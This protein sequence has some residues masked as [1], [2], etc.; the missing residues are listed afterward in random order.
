MLTLAKEDVLNSSG[1]GILPTFVDLND[2][3][4]TDDFALMVT[5]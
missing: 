4:V 5:M 3:Y 2:N 1:N